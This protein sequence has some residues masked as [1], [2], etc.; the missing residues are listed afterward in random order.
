M[1]DALSTAADITSLQETIEFE[2]TPVDQRYPWTDSYTLIKMACEKFSDDNAIEFLPTAAKDEPSL[3]ITYGQLLARLH[4]TA[5]LFNSL[6]VKHQDAVSIMLPTLPQTIYSIWGAQAAGIASP[7]NP[8]LEPRHLAEI[9]DVTDSKVFVTMAPMA[10]APDL[11]KTTLATIQQAKNLKH[12]VLITIPGLTEEPSGDIPDHIQV[13]DYS[14][15]IDGFNPASL[16]SKR[17]FSGDDIACYMHTGG[18]TGRP[19]VAQIT[20]S[21][22]AFV[23]QFTIDRN[24]DKPRENVLGA[25]PMFHIFGLIVSGIASIM[26]GNNIIIMSP[27]GY[28]QPN[29]I[30]NIWHHV[31]RFKFNNLCVVP[32]ILAAM[33]DVPVGDCDVSSLNE[34][35][36]GAAPLPLALK[37]KFQERFDCE[38]VNGYGMTETTVVLSVSSTKALPPEGGVGLRLP[39]AERIIAHIDQ[40]KITKVCGN[41]ETGVVLSRGPNIFAGYLEDI[42]NQDA[43]ADGWFNT[44]DMGYQDEDGF[45]FLV[46]RAK[47]LII[48]GGHNIDPVVIEEALEKHPAI[49]Q[50][51]AV[52]QPDDY[53]GELPIAYITLAP[54]AELDNQEL[55]SF[56]QAEISE[57]A[58]I[59][60]RLEIIDEIPL[61]AVG[62]IF[63]PELRRRA[64]EYALGLKLEQADIEATISVTHDTEKGLQS[65]IT[66]SDPK[67]MSDAE[68]ALQGFAIAYQL[69]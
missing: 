18:T 35:L 68:T 50:V 53:A 13:T 29:L 5:N 66:L 24:T 17:E 65:S 27:S 58:A 39:Y 4:Q 36:S 11:W 43:W 38:I 44:G 30:I 10:A 41:N 21:N 1:T 45:L 20:H 32:T 14:Q 63:K 54:G 22:F 47:D 15:S 62:K 64:T 67:R 2:Q 33:Y 69:Q 9:I 26:K 55:M 25:L 8:L 31:E 28:R 16:D 60:K 51:V 19:K 23:G 49:A 56:A 46:G 3:A 48:R 37:R 42:H 59:P 12:L 40:G 6:G 34:I 52:G 7:L 61:T 57:R